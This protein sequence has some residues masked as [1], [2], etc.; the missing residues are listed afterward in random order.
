MKRRV[1]WKK[2]FQVDGYKGRGGFFS[3]TGGMSDSVNLFLDL[4]F[5]KLPT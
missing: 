5:F 3:L 4:N 1:P 2:Q